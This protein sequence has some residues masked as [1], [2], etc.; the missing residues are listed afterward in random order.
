M[1]LLLT[2]RPDGIIRP[3]VSVSTMTLLLTIRPDGIIRPV[4]SVSTMTLLL[5]IF[6]IEI[7]SS[8]IM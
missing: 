6:I 3:V 4:V 8:K 7:Y 2:I 5:D 1:T